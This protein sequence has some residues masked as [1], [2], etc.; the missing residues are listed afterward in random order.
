MSKCHLRSQ[1]SRC[2]SRGYIPVKGKIEN[3][4]FK[5]TLV[6]LKDGPYR[7]FVNEPMPTGASRSVGQTAHVIIEQDLNPRTRN[8]SI[9][10]LFEE[11]LHAYNVFVAFKKLIPSRQKIF[12]IP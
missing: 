4:T 12:L 7:L 1:T 9:R 5:Q 10:K 2:P 3:Y 6:P 8:A 11:K